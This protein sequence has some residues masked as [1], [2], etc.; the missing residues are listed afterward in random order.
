MTFDFCSCSNIRELGSLGSCYEII[1][2]DQKINEAPGNQPDSIITLLETVN[3]VQ[4]NSLRKRQG[5]LN[6][7][8]QTLVWRTASRVW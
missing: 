7:V 8:A 4:G 2:L 5:S 3:H 1:V 6:K